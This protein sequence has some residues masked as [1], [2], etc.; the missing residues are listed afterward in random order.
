MFYH[1]LLNYYSPYNYKLPQVKM[2]KG[3]LIY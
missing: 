2:I 1:H 3:N